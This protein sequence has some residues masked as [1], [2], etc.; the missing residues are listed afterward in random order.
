MP[1]AVA[2]VR[3]VSGEEEVVTS[4]VKHHVYIEP[5]NDAP[6]FVEPFVTSDGK[7][8]WW[9]NTNPLAVPVGGSGLF[10]LNATDPDGDALTFSVARE[11]SHGTVS[12]VENSFVYQPDATFRGFDEFDVTVDD[13][14]G[15]PG[16]PRG[17]DEV[18]SAT[19][20]VFIQ[21]GKTFDVPL[22]MPYRGV[23]VERES[24]VV[25]LRRTAMIDETRAP[26][27][28]YAVST[29][30]TMGLAVMACEG[31]EVS[32]PEGCSI[33]PLGVRG[34]AFLRYVPFPDRDGTD[35]FEV[36]VTLGE[37][38]QSVEVS[39]EV[40]SI[41][42]P[43]RVLSSPSLRAPVL[44]NPNGVPNDAYADVPIRLDTAFDDEGGTLSVVVSVTDTIGL[45]L[46]GKM[47][48]P[49]PV[50]IVPRLFSRS[51]ESPPHCARR[52]CRLGQLP[53]VVLA[54]CPNFCPTVAS[55][56]ALQYAGLMPRPEGSRRNR[57]LSQVLPED[58]ATGSEDFVV[59]PD[60]ELSLLADE[61]GFVTLPTGSDEAAHVYYQVGASCT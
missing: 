49:R 21:V 18:K 25:P 17:I 56:S 35:A 22:M 36:S 4:V 16:H 55:P 53:V 8:Q 61:D 7:A 41:N 5:V 51:D 24:Y 19:G 12:I 23:A 48:S 33:P 1:H 10:T 43:P 31:M 13:S 39:F 38:T 46:R 54:A 32:D 28:R 57:R 6:E 59:D 34:A 50:G 58:L 20:T 29:D 37:L 45:G 52:R 2:G 27:L 47:V 11:P 44:V 26:L 3:I 30:P 14:L 9:I 60:T 15:R 42:D 40:R